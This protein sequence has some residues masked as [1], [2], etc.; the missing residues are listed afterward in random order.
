MAITKDNKQTK[1]DKAD[2]LLR[3]ESSGK[4]N[5]I[6]E[7]IQNESEDENIKDEDI[8][9]KIINNANQYFLLKILSPQIEHNEDKKRIHKDKLIS[10]IKIFLVCQFIIL[11]F[12]LFGIITMIFVF[13]GLKNDLELSYLELIVKFVSL[14]ITSIVAELIAM[15]HFIVSNVFDTSITGLVELYKDATGNRNESIKEQENS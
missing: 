2:S 11:L 10:I 1:G 7:E 8:L 4:K 13:H 12:L 5:D 14:Y 15:L 9:E 3:D 6:E